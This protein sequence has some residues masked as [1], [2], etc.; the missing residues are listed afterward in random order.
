M[1]PRLSDVRSI[2]LRSLIQAALLPVI[3]LAGAAFA[4]AEALAQELPAETED[5]LRAIYERGEFGAGGYSF[6]WT[7]A[8]TGYTRLERTEGAEVAEI[9]H[10]DADSGERSVLVSAADLRPA[11]SSGPLTVGAYAFSQGLDVVLIRTGSELWTLDRSSGLLR[12]VAEGVAGGSV[13]GLLSPEGDRI[14]F[15]RSQNLYVTDV[16]GSNTVQ[17]TTDGHDEMRNGQ[18]TWS[19]D[20]RHVAFVQQD[21][22]EIRLRPMLEPVDPSYPEVREVRFA[23]VGG[24]IASLRVGI[25]PAGGG[26]V[27]WASIPAPEEGFYLGTV[28]WAESPDE[29]LVEWLSRSRDVREFYLVQASTGDASRIY[30]EENDAWAVASYGTNLGVDWVRDGEAFIVLSE[31]EGWRRAYL[32]SRA[33]ERLATLTPD[34]VDVIARGWVDE[35]AGWLY[36][37][38]SPN[39]GVRHYLYRARLDGSGSPERVTPQG[40]SGWHVYDASPDPRWAVRNRSS[41]E[42]PPVIELLRFP[43]HQ[44]VRVLEDNASLRERVDPLLPGNSEFL[45]IDI[46]SEGGV[47]VA[48]DAWMIKP[49][50]FD[51]SQVYPLFL[52]VYGEPHGQTV[53]DRWSGNQLYHQTIADLGYLVVSIDNRGT[54]APKGAAWRRSIFPTLGP[55]STEEQAA[56]VQELGRMRP[57]VDLSRVGTWGW[58]GGGSNTLNALFRRPDVFHVGIAVVPKPQAHLYNAW[59]QEIYMRTVEENPEGYRRAS[60]INF[61][62][63]LEGD[64]L[65]VTGTGETNTHV[66]IVE[67]LVDRLIALGKPFDYMAYPNRNHGISEGEGTSVHLRMLMVRYLLQHLPPG[68][69]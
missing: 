5:R 8:G 21:V 33:G 59:F 40:Q 48:M 67:G 25:V 45:E 30:G 15:Q 65:I 47:R 31:K 34:G 68:P 29:L 39:D 62:E 41:F 49:R 36:Y 18:P 46:E 6:E 11:G 17:L 7:P 2:V 3:L 57:Y 61:A 38:A 9:L 51:P 55:L 35:P 23:R 26:E 66:Q 52:Y 20:G 54:P 56:G 14:V 12:K 13:D 16:A 63:G 22:S 37:H 19:P 4:S 27:R 1:S 53:M 60:P 42:E 69:A 32:Y 44:V 58:S 28:E 64:L 50:D 43:D 10:Y 24:T